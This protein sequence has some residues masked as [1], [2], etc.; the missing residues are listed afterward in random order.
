MDTCPSFC[1]NIPVFL[2]VPAAGQIKMSGFVGV[3]LPAVPVA[4]LWPIF[5]VFL[6]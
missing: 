2:F 3:G 1:H 5:L 4:G 6:H